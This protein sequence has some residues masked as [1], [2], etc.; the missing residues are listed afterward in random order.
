MR[1]RATASGCNS[2][3]PTLEGRDPQQRRRPRGVARRFAR[4]LAACVL[5][6]GAATATDIPVAGWI[7]RVR[8]DPGLVV[9]AK[10]D[11]GADSSSL[12]AHDMRWFQREGIDWVSFEVL[13]IEGQRVRLERPVIRI[14]RVRNALGAGQRRPVVMLGICVGGVYRATEVSLA[15]RSWMNERMLIGRRFLGSHLLVD[16]ARKYLLEPSC[17]ETG[18]P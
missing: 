14:T 13:G 18:P 11:T 17:K 1:R 8:I 9:Q 7:E 6:T 16:S 2:C 4:A 15:D 5:W 12:D 3:P 10:L